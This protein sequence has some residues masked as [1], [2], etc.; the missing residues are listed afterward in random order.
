[1]TDNDHHPLPPTEDGETS[2]QKPGSQNQKTLN[3]K[4]QNPERQNPE[5]TS[6]DIDE[7]KTL[8]ATPGDTAPLSSEPLQAED[9]VGKSIGKYQITGIVGRGG[10]G[11]VLRGHDPT[12]DR[13]VAIKVLPE[14][15]SDNEVAL[16]RFQSEAR[17]AGKLSHA[18][19][20]AIHEIGEHG[21]L[22]FLVMELLTGGSVS[23]EVQQHGA[24]SLLEATR[25][26]IDAC[27]GVAAAH[28]QGLVHRDIKPANLVRSADGSVK[29]TDFGL[30]KLTTSPDDLHLTRTGTVIG[31]PYFMSPEQCQGKTVDAR[32]DIYALG[33]TYFCL[34]TG[35]QPYD[36]SDSVV[37]VMFAHCNDPIPDPRSFNSSV[38]PACST[39][40]A[41]AMAK[42]PDHR[43]Q[44][45]D[46][47]RDDLQS[48]HAALSGTIPIELPSG[49]N[50]PRLNTKSGNS[51]PRRQILI[52][53]SIA[54]ISLVS[55]GYFG[56]GF[57]SSTPS[58][59][60]PTGEPIK[61]G[62]LQS[63]SGTMSVSGT[64]LVDSILL[65]ISEINEAGGLMGRPV[66]AVVADGR[67]K[68][69][70]YAEEAE[71][72]IV[73]EN[74]CTVFGCWTSYSRKTVRPLFERHD[75]LLVYPVQYEG[76]EISPNIIYLGA[77]P[78][79]Q[80]IPAVRWV[81]E[82]LGKKKIFL[83]GSDYVFP[84]TANEIIKDQLTEYDAQVVGE[85][86]VP[87]GGSRF[88]SVIDQIKN[89][90][91]EIILN[92]LNGESNVAF[93]R[94]LRDAGID[95][96]TV[97]CLS[98]SIGEQ[99]LRSL[100]L[101]DVE[102]DYAASTYF[103]SL[104]NE[105]NQNFVARFKSNHPHRVISDPMQDA[106]IGVHLWAQAV[107]DAEST[108]PKQIRRAMLGQRIA[109]PEGNIRI[110]PE[111]QHCFKTPRVGQ[112]QHDGQFRIVW[113]ADTPIRP[114]P[115]PSTRTAEDWKVFLHDLYIGWGNS[116]VSR[117][118]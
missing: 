105:I 36:E 11:V 93:F 41:N 103:Q 34:L 54:L 45:A 14:K 48:V 68:S 116:W 70:V 19:V 37:Q 74:V 59:A 99:E 114:E 75:H 3:P 89:S 40:I 115:F 10:M 100:D 67:S 63:L 5:T 43:Y 77:A 52:A 98:F 112:I 111:T 94:D 7:T 76:M 15:M 20:A 84:R 18:N 62:V 102:G 44:S 33:A 27:Q 29:L 92:T 83:I 28:A 82:S 35:R 73:D 6:S 25:I 46:A 88:D 31:T 61:V 2:H 53:A 69:S 49:S 56:L 16:S 80:I 79:Q 90:Q 51:L 64:S 72:L 117:S 47:M 106:Y 107:R 71:R 87:L 12:L 13:D 50:L 22:H 32:T 17:A 8:A 104:D 66:E 9:W 1:M 101:A 85:T 4:T 96:A 108:E 81:T 26:L 30:A 55:L 86:Y 60:V 109:A 23:E 21:S 38:P 118:K 110:D 113:T 42:D 78:N 57:F 91:P 39:I 58:V 95:Q 24:C 97:P 65:A